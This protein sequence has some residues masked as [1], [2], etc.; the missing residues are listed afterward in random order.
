MG[1]TYIA[2]EGADGSGKSTQVRRL[3]QR[4]GALATFEPGATS[5]G[6]RLRRL[7]LDSDQPLVSPRAETL[8][9][10]AD[11]A[12]HL[13]SVVLPALAAGRHVI[14]DRSLFSSMAYQGAGRGLGLDAVYEVN[15][16]AVGQRFPDVV[17]YLELDP[18]DA[19]PRITRALD[20]LE[21]ESEAFHRQVHEAYQHMAARFNWI[22]IDA[23][24]DIET[25]HAHI[26]EQLAPWLQ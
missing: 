20:R 7:L 6:A 2:I 12:Q 4:C 23:S 8:L 17:V 14:S 5:L 13:E 11:R 1:A 26:W 24:G 10:A 3:A 21:Q 9:M 19:G 16:W 18:T 25:V 22:V 15:A